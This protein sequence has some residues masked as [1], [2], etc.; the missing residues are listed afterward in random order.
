MTKYGPLFSTNFSARLFFR[1]PIFL[2]HKAAR[3]VAPDI[4]TI[5]SLPNRICADLDRRHLSHVDDHVAGPRKAILFDA[6]FVFKEAEET[7]V[8]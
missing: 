6:F 1:V 3:P 4:G 7:A 8:R 2:R 5:N